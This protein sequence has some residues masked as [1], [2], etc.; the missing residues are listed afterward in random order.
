MSPIML[1]GAIIIAYNQEPRLTK[2]FLISLPILALAMII[3]MVFSVPLFKSIQTKAD[4]INLVFREG[5]TGVRVIRA[6]NQANENKI[7][8]VGPTPITPTPEL[9]PLPWY[10]S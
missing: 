1:V 4:R 8:S 7:G 5:L 9:R 2:I 10:R 6:F 3:I